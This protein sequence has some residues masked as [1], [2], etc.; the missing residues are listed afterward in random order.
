MSLLSR[1]QVRRTAIVLVC[2]ALSTG[3]SG[4]KKDDS[5]Q[6]LV[7]A[8]LDRALASP[9]TFIHVDQDLD[10]RT[11]VSGQIADS[12]RYRLLLN[13]DG[14]P[15]WQ[16]VVRD[17]AVADLFLN[18][19]SV[20]TYAGAGSSP[21]VDVVT[22][23]QDLY[24]L[25]PESARR[26][27]PPPPLNQLPH[28]Q[29]L[30]PSLALAA[31]QKGKWVVDKSG[32]PVLPTLGT[33]AEK[34]ATSPFLR[35]MLMLEAVRSEVDG[36]DPKGIKKWTKDDLSPA[37]K[38]KDDPFP[39]PGPGEDRYDVFQA[40]LPQI[41]ATSKGSR[42]DPPS[43][44]ALRKLAIYI[45]D[46]KV[47]AIRENYDILDRLEDLARLYQIPLQLKTATGTVTEQ[48]IG[49]LI[50]ELVQASR[51]VPFRVH[52]EELLLSYP[53]TRPDIELPSP[54]IPADLSLLP[55]QGKAEESA[56][57]QP[58]SEPV[59]SPAIP[60]GASP[61]TSPTTPSTAP[62]ATPGAATAS[63]SPTG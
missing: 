13:V 39:K 31:L 44:D 52:E 45:K 7:L 47:V 32:A 26:Q 58:T 9:R 25:L 56:T 4:C 5:T 41:T 49:Q 38:P 18:P 22:D 42:P 60:N 11:T 57:T 6:R 54:A 16:Q 33:S 30:Q 27:I 62:S 50:V 34:L 20:T 55:G 12:L 28:T 19:A 59:P 3:L 23:Y 1:R 2:C 36:L 15:I 51:P 17:D 35:P 29:A 21:A 61:G 46:G 40:P 24:R 8:A 48:R 37:F 43:D 10:H 14:L 63:P 53:A